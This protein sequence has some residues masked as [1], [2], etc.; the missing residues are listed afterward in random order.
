M[1]D[2]ILNEEFQKIDELLV[3][4]ERKIILYLKSRENLSP[5]IKNS[6]SNFTPKHLG[7]STG[8][9]RKDLPKRIKSI[10]NKSLSEAVNQIVIL[11]KHEEKLLSLFGKSEKKEI[12]GLIENVKK[13]LS[14]HDERVPRDEFEYSITRLRVYSLKAQ[15]MLVIEDSY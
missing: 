8:E 10:L 9:T 11:G 7:I 12:V 2:I 1:K 3:D 5:F 13:F 14:F 6:G 4:V 15:T